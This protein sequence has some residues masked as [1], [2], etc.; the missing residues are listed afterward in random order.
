ML[1]Q[2]C[3]VWILPNDCGNFPATWFHVHI[4]ITGGICHPWC[5]CQRKRT[6]VFWGGG[7]LYAGDMFLLFW[8]NLAQHLLPEQGYT[9]HSVAGAMVVNKESSRFSVALAPLVRL[10]QWRAS[11]FLPTA[12]CT[13]FDDGFLMMHLG[14]RCTC[15]EGSERDKIVRDGTLHLQLSVEINYLYFLW[16]NCHL[17]CILMCH[18]WYL[19]IASVPTRS[20]DFFFRNRPFL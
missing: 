20:E 15:H 9:Q 2:T 18:N 1:C 3:L 11:S 13:A 10:R 19:T 4:Y 12:R 8:S 14:N 5:C 7:V 16:I 6:V 17:L